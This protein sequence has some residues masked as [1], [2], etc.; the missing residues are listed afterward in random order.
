[1]TDLQP[2]SRGD[3]PAKQQASAP[4]IAGLRQRLEARY[5][6]TVREI[7]SYPAPIP[8]CD[9][10]Y[11]H[12]LETRHGCAQALRALDQP[13]A[14]EADALDGLISFLRDA[15]SLSDREARALAD[16]VMRR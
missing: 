12:L 1:M 6:E 4:E 16:H 3:R 2:A 8:A 9:Q 7:R 5:A 15:V 11:N 13:G 14:A 10:H